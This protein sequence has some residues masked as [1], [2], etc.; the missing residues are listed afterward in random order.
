MPPPS[1]GSPAGVWP[2]TATWMSLVAP[3]AIERTVPVTLP[4]GP[5]ALTAAVAAK[6]PCRTTAPCAA[7][8][9]PTMLL[10][11]VP[12]AA[13]NT[14]IGA[15]ASVNGTSVHAGDG[16]SMTLF[17]RKPFCA[18]EPSVRYTVAGPSD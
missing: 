10:V 3:L 2:Q 14:S 8:Q 17:E 1:A 16:V 5:T 9:P 18:V 13:A 7:S 4:G 6:L 15:V 12:G 11:L